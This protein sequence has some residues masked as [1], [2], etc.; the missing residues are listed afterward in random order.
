MPKIRAD[1]M[2]VD[3]G[4]AETRTKA[5]ALVI[6]GEVVARMP[7]GGERRVDKPGEQLPEG[8]ELRLKGDGLRYVSRGGLKIEKALDVFGID[9][10]GVRALDL[11]ASTGG[12]TDCLLQRGATSVVAVDVGRGQL[13]DRLRRDPR[14]TSLEQVNARDLPASLGEFGLVVADLSFISLRLVL[15]SA[16]ARVA[17]GGTIV[18][19]VKPQFECGR[20]WVEKGGVVRDE[21]ARRRAVTDVRDA[22]EGLGCEVLGDAESP[23]KGPAGNVE[24]L[25]AARRRV[26]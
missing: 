26:G 9:P 20:E 16:L 8:T 24:Y 13:H 23:I 5:Q 25:V 12:F 14:V 1:L 15:P 4:L 18:V 21:G 10:T 11:G 19:L 6:A 17:T 22:L 2:V 3:Q 7:G